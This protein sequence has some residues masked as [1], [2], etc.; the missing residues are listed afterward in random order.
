MQFDTLHLTFRFFPSFFAFF[1]RLCSIRSA[2]RIEKKRTRSHIRAAFK[3]ELRLERKEKKRKGLSYR[4]ERMTLYDCVRT[5]SKEHRFASI[6]CSIPI[7]SLI[8]EITSL[9]VRRP[10]VLRFHRRG[11]FARLIARILNNYVEETG[12]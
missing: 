11:R 2:V 6:R 5:R 12:D 7:F 9:G 8:R 1:L 3:Y 4:C 10:R